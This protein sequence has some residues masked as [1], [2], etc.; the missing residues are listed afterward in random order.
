MDN[1][2]T[3]ASVIGALVLGVTQLIKSSVPDNKFLPIINIFVGIVLGVAYAAS[4]TPADL[5][6]YAWG[7]E[8]PRKVTT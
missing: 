6:L 3:A 4:F 1:I 8:K 5:V 7:G 2:L